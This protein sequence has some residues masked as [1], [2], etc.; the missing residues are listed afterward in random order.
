MPTE[1]LKEEGGGC[2]LQKMDSF[3]LG[4]VLGQG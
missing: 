3:T 2:E 1:S 4:A